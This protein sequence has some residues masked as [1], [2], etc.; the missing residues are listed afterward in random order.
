MIPLHTTFIRILRAEP[1][2]GADPT[3]PQPEPT[4]VAENIRASISSPSGREQVASGAS[5][6]V[7]EFGLSC[8]PCD[9]LGTDQVQDQTT[10]AIYEVVWARRRTG[11]GLDHIHG[12]L[13]QVSGVVSR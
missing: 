1:D 11:F 7:V 8:D 13:K 5:Q 12:S 2:S 9:L 4:I 6:A 10:E 3:D